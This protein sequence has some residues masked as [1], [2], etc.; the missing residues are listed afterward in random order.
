VASAV[1]IPLGPLVTVL[2]TSYNYERFLAD[3]I[4]SALHQDYG[5]VE[6]IVVDDGS[7]D[8][9][10]GLAKRFPV[11]VLARQHEG[12]AP[13]MLAGVREAR[14]ELVIVLN[15]DDVLHP[16]YVRRL[17]EARAGRE[18]VFVYTGAYL[19]GPHVGVPR[20]G[21]RMH[22]RPFSSERLAE[23]NYILSGALVPRAAVLQI[24][25]Y[26]AALPAL[27]DWDFWM[28]LLAAGYVGIPLDEPLYYYRQHSAAARNKANRRR[29]ERLRREMVRRNGAASLRVSITH[30]LR[31]VPLAILLAMWT[32]APGLVARLSRRLREVP[33]PGPSFE[34]VRMAV[35]EPRFAWLGGRCPM[36]APSA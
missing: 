21:L 13:A 32:L 29:N 36:H 26:D 7:T 35:A 20:A 2:V 27:E 28:R 1:A 19:F 10:V 25:G 5:A 4:E 3:A 15:A 12:L 33:F 9:S 6:V 24:G 30:F 31:F 23:G 11:R 16:T 18:R 22:A 17:V 14:G 8:G 34:P